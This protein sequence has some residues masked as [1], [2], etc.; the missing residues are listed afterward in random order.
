MLDELDTPDP[1]PV[2]VLGAGSWGTTLARVL[3]SQGREVRLYCRH[4]ERAQAI[5]ADRVNEAYLPGVRLP[6]ALR[7]TSDLG[8]AVR[9]APLLLM[10]VPSRAFSAVLAEALAQGAAPRAA[11]SATKGLHPDS[12]ETMTSLMAQALGPEVPVASLSGPN[13][14]KEVA[15]D[16]PAAAVMACAHPRAGKLLQAVFSTPTFRVY[17]S[18]DVVGVEVAGAMKNVLALASGMLSELGLGA[19]A[20][21][22]LLTRGLEE[23]SRLGA[24]MGAK[25]STFR[26]LAG[27]GDMLA[28]CTSPLS[29][30]YRAGRMAARGLD[31]D[32][33]RA[34]MHQ[35]VEG[36]ETVQSALQLAGRLG[37]EMPVAAQVQAVLFEGR[38]ADVAVRVLMERPPRVEQDEEAARVQAAELE[39]GA[40]A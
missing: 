23:I 27:M 20:L 2:A 34:E 4:P 6:D 32:S 35:V 21:A 11:V 14:A 3:A 38:P 39:A 37:V 22:A 30:N 17:T 16:Q 40:E 5:Q 15:G 19:N 29:R 25:R 26:G 12:L 7:A 36:I 13:L 8:E 31:P 33:I 28:T 1:W 9:G 18:T 10:A 24:A